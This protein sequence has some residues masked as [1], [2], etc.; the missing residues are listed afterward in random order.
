MEST[1]FDQFYNVK[2]LLYLGNYKDSLEEIESIEV[3]EDI[4]NIRKKFYCFLNYLESDKQEELNQLLKDLKDSNDSSKIYYNIFRIFIVFYIKNTVK[5]ETLSKIYNDLISLENVSPFIQPA[6][7]LICLILLETDDKEKFIML[8]GMVKDNCE[9]LMLRLVYFIRLG[10]INEAK[11]I[12]EIINS[13]YNDFIGAQFST[14][15]CSLYE[16]SNISETVRIIQEVK[17]NSKL[18]PKLF[19]LIAVLM[20]QNKQF[21]EAIKPLSLGYD[22]SMKMNLNSGD[23]NVILVN[24]ITCYRNL[25]MEE[26]CINTEEIL[27]KNDPNN[28]YFNKIKEFEE[29]FSSS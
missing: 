23:M 24:L 14:Y 3:D 16:S 28:I 10:N 7:Y 19:N 9:I 12:S 1:I 26:E 8:S 15:I 25:D 29:L 4:Q 27:R 5:E 18:T 22:I 20:M 17:S 11:K 6:I 13:K 2:N 21:K